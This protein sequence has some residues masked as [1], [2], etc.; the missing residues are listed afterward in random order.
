MGS[1]PHNIAFLISNPA[2]FQFDLG[3]SARNLAIAEGW[4]FLEA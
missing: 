1:N 3:H 4:G 2:S